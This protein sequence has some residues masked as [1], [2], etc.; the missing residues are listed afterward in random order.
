ME[1]ATSSPAN[2]QKFPLS[3]KGRWREVVISID[4]LYNSDPGRSTCVGR[5]Y[6]N[7]PGEILHFKIEEKERMLSE[8]SPLYLK[9]MELGPME[10]FVYLIG[11]RKTGE[12]AVVDPAWEVDRILNVAESEGLTIRHILLSHSHYD[13]I[14]GVEELLSKVDADVYIDRNEFRIFDSPWGGI[15]KT[16]M[17]DSIELGGI[18]IQFL[19]T[20]G[21]TPGSQCFL[22]DRN[23]ISGDTLFIEGCGRCD[24][25]GGSPEAMY[26]SLTRVILP[27]SNET[28]LYPG[29]HYADRPVSTL[30]DE[31]EKNPYL[32]FHDVDSFVKFRMRPR[33]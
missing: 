30:G 21:H 8:E 12:A 25:N 32:R 27:L 5:C 23:L 10:N 6:R 11:S 26:D 22:I 1:K 2:L 17:G 31:K 7:L 19:H 16:R 20:P 14:N 29:H 15:R 4:S 28:V 9:Q 33:T 3:C 18:P 24:L 13:H